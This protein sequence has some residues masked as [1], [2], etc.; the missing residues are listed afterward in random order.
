[1]TI[2]CEKIKA[3]V[4][5][6]DVCIPVLSALSTRY[7]T[8]L[9][10]RCLPAHIFSYFTVFVSGQ[11]RW[12]GR[13]GHRGR[14]GFTFGLEHPEEI[15]GVQRNRNT[16]TTGWQVTGPWCGLWL[17]TLI[18]IQSPRALYDQYLAQCPDHLGGQAHSWAH[19]SHSRHRLW[20]DSASCIQLSVM[21][22]YS[23]VFCSP[24]LVTHFTRQIRKLH[25]ARGSRGTCAGERP[26]T[27]H[28][29]SP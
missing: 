16:V 15:K 6:A 5:L 10:T 19:D 7:R 21:C 28:Q 25:L 4:C 1:M 18:Y 2:K 27:S 9:S 20:P 29:G 17:I 22:L 3:S 14:G 23:R 12:L 8:Q 24:P 26:D 13:P 11:Q